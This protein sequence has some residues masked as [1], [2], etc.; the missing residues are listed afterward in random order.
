MPLF[1]TTIW[2]VHR[3][4]GPRN[5]LARVAGG[6]GGRHE[7][8]MGTPLDAV[9]ES[10][11]DPHVV[12]LDVSTAAT[13]P[14]PELELARR[15][16][17][18]A[19]G[20]AWILVAEP[21]SLAAAEQ[22]FD[23][24]GTRPLRYPPDA[25]SLQ[26]AVAAAL[27]ELRPLP[28]SRRVARDRLA[29]RFARW[30]GRGEPAGLG[31]ALEARLAD[32][33]L[34]VS[35]EV[36][37]GRALLLRH[38]HQVSQTE[39]GPFLRV[40]CSETQRSDQ[41]L[42]QIEDALLVEGALRRDARCGICLEDLDRLAAPA[43]TRVLDWIEFGLP[44]A[45]PAPLRRVRWM[46]STGPEASRLDTRLALAFAELHVRTTP[47]RQQTEIIEPFVADTTRA[48]A[49]VR[50]ERAPVFD[51]P[52]LD[53]LRGEPWPGNLAE[54]EALVVRTLAHASAGA[55]TIRIADLRFDPKPAPDLVP[56]EPRAASEPPAAEPPDATG[57]DRAIARL[58][59][60]VA[61]EVR[62][63]LVSIRTFS[64]L[65]DEH[66]D[67]QEFRE[68]FGRLVSEDIRRIEN[69]VERLER[70]GSEPA[71]EPPREIDVTA[72]LE[73]LL[74]A[75]RPRIQAKRLLVLKELDRARPRAFGDEATLRDALGGLLAHALSEVPERGDLYLASRHHPSAEGTA[76]MRILFRY[77]VRPAASGDASRPTLRDTVLE[78]VRA[79]SLIRSQGGSLTIDTTAASETLIV[80]D[81]PAPPAT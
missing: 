56:S 5:A 79:E 58:A 69:V 47:L 11:R 55:E 14:E 7:I 16:Q 28:L 40:A 36:G 32:E 44:F 80:I 1:D 51:P 42:A 68:R 52:A 23:T 74:D 31:L 75:E 10:A 24:L 66:Y 48:W 8:V 72:L 6:V 73:A 46:A 3:E 17:A 49:A 38:A 33:P 35:G 2:I 12:V 4:S 45:L 15:A 29:A 43:Q 76:G 20:C 22:L 77:R 57:D 62:N 70:M 60:A 25:R 19:P 30:F 21:A 27:S 9:F 71:A 65:L 61:H 37:T 67:D 39:P 13:D 26:A 54:L 78:H 18:R 63:P 59:A 53:L 81:L 64:E 41:L 34:L 50:G